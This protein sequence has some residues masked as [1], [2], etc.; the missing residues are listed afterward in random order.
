M[1]ANYYK[2]SARD[3]P[4]FEDAHKDDWKSNMAAGVRSF[5]RRVNRI[6][7]TLLPQ[8]ENLKQRKLGRSAYNVY[9]DYKTVFKESIIYVKRK[10][11]KSALSFAGVG[12]V[13]YVYDKNPDEQSFTDTL[14]ESANKLLQLSDL[15]RN[16][17]SCSSVQRV[18]KLH[19][20]GRLRRQ[21]L[22]LFSIV[23]EQPLSASCDLYENHCTYVQPRWSS[24]WSRV[25]D[26]GMM[27]HWFML[28][29]SM[30]DY[31]VNEE[32]LLDCPED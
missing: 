22:G 17:T 6:N 30:V 21:S 12:T 13:C 23:L 16:P 9:F 7:D 15:I 27:G 1:L 5:L 29:R 10:P 11:F 8:F 25:V 19:S 3:R 18:L 4:A 31:D 2:I 32:E 20:E 24:L 28:E 26:V 14:M